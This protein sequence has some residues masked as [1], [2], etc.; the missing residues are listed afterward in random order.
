[1]TDKSQ[2][3]SGAAP[4]PNFAEWI[5]RHP[6]C[7]LRCGYTPIEGMKEYLLIHGEEAKC[8]RCGDALVGQTDPYP[9]MAAAP[10]A[11]PAGPRVIVNDTVRLY[12]CKGNADFLHSNEADFLRCLN[13]NLPAPP[14]PLPPPQERAQDYGFTKKDVREII[15]AEA[16]LA[17]ETRTESR[18]APDEKLIELAKKWL[19]E[20]GYEQWKDGDW[21][22]NG[23]EIGGDLPAILADYAAAAASRIAQLE[24]ERESLQIQLD[25][26]AEIL[27]EHTSRLLEAEA[28][29]THARADKELVADNLAKA[30]AT[31][32]EQ[33]KRVSALME[34]LEPFAVFWE[35]AE[36]KHMGRGRLLTDAFK[37][38]ARV[39][40]QVKKEEKR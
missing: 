20:N 14:A 19:T 32:S 18:L 22:I 31:C 34:A 1:M 6:H 12:P 25:S 5:G 16:A 30:L 26:C 38:A 36:T 27:R 17:E 13:C 3:L 35:A 7:C 40:E 4:A 29:L 39:Y 9:E 33:G 37:A 15:T 8:C 24:R 10:V 2:P 21:H 11:V 23:Y 28:A